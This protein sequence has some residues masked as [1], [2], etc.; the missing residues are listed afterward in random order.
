RQ[1]QRRSLLCSS[2]NRDAIQTWSRW[3]C[4]D[5]LRSNNSRRSGNKSTFPFLLPTQKKQM[6][7]ARPKLYCKIDSPPSRLRRDK[8]S[9]I[10]LADKKLMWRSLRNFTSSRD[11]CSRRKHF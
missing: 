10:R 11:F 1:L 8:Q 2:R 6:L 3:I 4:K 5:R 9:L 7:G